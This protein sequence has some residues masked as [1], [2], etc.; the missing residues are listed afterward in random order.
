MRTATT[1]SPPTGYAQ[2]QANQTRK[3]ECPAAHRR[4]IHEGEEEEEEELCRA[5]KGRRRIPFITPFPQ[6]NRL[7]T[8]DGGSIVPLKCRVCAGGLYGDPGGDIRGRY[9]K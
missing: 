6:R 7:L 9:P 2:R 4:A 3:S 1:I 5:E 8:Q